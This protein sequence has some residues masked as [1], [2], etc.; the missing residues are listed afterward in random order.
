MRTLT[1]RRNYQT[2]LGT[3]LKIVKER[4]LPLVEDVEDVEDVEI[5]GAWL[6][7]RT[8]ALSRKF[9]M[10]MVRS[11]VLLRWIVSRHGAALVQ[12]TSE[13]PSVLE[14]VAKAHT[15]AHSMNSLG[16]HCNTTRFS[17]SSSYGS[18]HSHLAGDLH[19]SVRASG[20]EKERSCHTACATSPELVAASRTG[21][22]T[23]TGIRDGSV[24]VDQ[25][26]LQ[27][28][29][30]LFSA[31]KA[32]NQEENISNFDYLAAAKM[33]K[34]ATVRLSTK[35]VTV[36]PASIGCAV[37]ELCKKCEDEVS[38]RRSAVSQD[39]TRE[40]A[41]RPTRYCS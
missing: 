26:W 29:N 40:V 25:R 34:T 12:K 13:G 23:K 17:Q 33:F 30:K 9:N 41:W 14:G 38:G 32:G 5:D 19:A 37:S 1:A 24:L 16:R 21:V 8:I 11:F 4:A 2:A 6:R 10:P 7:T 3:F 31:L 27:W 15:C 36:A 22:S 20:V 28:V 39:T 35:N 18:V